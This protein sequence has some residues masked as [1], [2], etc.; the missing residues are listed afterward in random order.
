MT[1]IV[2]ALQVQSTCIQVA[3]AQ[4]CEIIH[5]KVSLCLNVVMRNCL[6]FAYNYCARVTRGV[7]PIVLVSQQ[8]QSDHTVNRTVMYHI[9]G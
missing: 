3:L 6:H 5:M 8:F 1:N 2:F 4:F 7:V 9:L